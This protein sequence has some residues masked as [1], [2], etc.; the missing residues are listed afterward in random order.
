[1]QV[2]PIASLTP[3]RRPLTELLDGADVLLVEDDRDIA[4]MYRRG[5]TTA[6][7]KVAVAGTASGAMTQL[8]AGPPAVVLLDLRLP[9]DDGFHV[10]QQMRADPTLARIPVLVLSNYG[11]ASTIRR[12]LD[13]GAV[14]YLVK[15][16]V[17]PSEVAARVRSY[18][19]GGGGQQLN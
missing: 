5:L 15:A 8:R 12:A 9:G 3:E 16:N 19:R 4:E 11:E 18:L 6:G 1:M 13:L 17:T 2:L 14:E 10:L 7:L